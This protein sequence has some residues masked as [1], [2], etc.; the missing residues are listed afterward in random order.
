MKELDA[1]IKAATAEAK[2]AAEKIKE[3]EEATST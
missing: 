2:A 1:L 3:A